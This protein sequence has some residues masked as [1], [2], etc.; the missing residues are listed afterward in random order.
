MEGLRKEVY[1]GWDK[2]ADLGSGIFKRW[3][4]K[5]AKDSGRANEIE[6]LEDEQKDLA[7]NNINGRYD[8]R[9]S[10][11]ANRLQE[12]GREAKNTR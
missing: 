8:K 4:S 2:L 7:K 1:M 11:I 10:W 12:L 6:K 3:F 5:E 9:L